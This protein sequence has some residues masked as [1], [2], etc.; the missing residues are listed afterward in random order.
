MHNSEKNSGDLKRF[1]VTWT[2]M[3]IPSANDCVKHLQR[4]I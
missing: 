3:K 4:A 2:P 1:A